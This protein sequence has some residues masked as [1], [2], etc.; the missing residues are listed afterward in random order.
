MIQNLIV[1]QRTHGLPPHTQIYYK[2]QTI[3][4][5]S[6]SLNTP[7]VKVKDVKVPE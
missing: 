2:I 7:N 4:E 3:Q 5:E 6:E 1:Q